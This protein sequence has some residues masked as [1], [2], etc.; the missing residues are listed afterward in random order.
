MAAASHRIQNLEAW[1]QSCQPAAAVSRGA[2]VCLES[3]LP[4]DCGLWLRWLAGAGDPVEVVKTPGLPKLCYRAPLPV[5]RS[6]SPGGQCGQCGGSRSLVTAHSG[7][8]VSSHLHRR[9]SADIQ[10]VCP[11]VPGWIIVGTCLNFDKIYFQLFL[12]QK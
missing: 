2:R 8:I 11:L 10:E 12:E 1:C 3:D 5:H 9:S 6:R 4:D 7:H